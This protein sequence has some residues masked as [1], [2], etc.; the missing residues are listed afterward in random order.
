MGGIGFA[1]TGCPVGYS[2]SGEANPA[3]TAGPLGARWGE[4]MPH[5][6]KIGQLVDYH[7]PRGI[8]APRGPYL[9][10]AQLPMRDGEFEYHIR[11]PNEMHERI[12]PESQLSIAKVTLRHQRSL[13]T[14]A[15]VSMP[16][17]SVKAGECSFFHLEPKRHYLNTHPIWK[18]AQRKQLLEKRR[19]L[20]M[21]ISIAPSAVRET[22]LNAGA[23]MPSR[24]AQFVLATNHAVKR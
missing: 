4:S 18:R 21:R 2:P 5:K 13:N 10:A 7:P 16:V 19:R 17:R 20:L 9:I 3:G 24:L 22:A 8:Y 1:T 15:I 14:R 12:A 6:F 23:A 11:H